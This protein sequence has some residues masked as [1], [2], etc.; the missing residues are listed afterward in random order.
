[1]CGYRPRHRF[2][3]PEPIYR[4]AGAGVWLKIGLIW[5]FWICLFISSSAGATPLIVG[6]DFSRVEFNPYVECIENAPAGLT[7]KDVSSESYSAEFKKLTVGVFHKARPTSV[8]WCRFKLDPKGLRPTS[9]R[10]EL[11]L[12]ISHA[13]VINAILYIPQPGHDG[14]LFL[15]LDSG[16]IGANRPDDLGYLT[17]VFRIPQDFA[18]DRFFYLRMQTPLVHDIKINVYSQDAFNNYAWTELA[19]RWLTIGILVAMILYNLALYLILKERAY[20]FY[21]YF[22]GLIMIHLMVSYGLMKMISYPL[23][24]ALAPRTITIGHLGWLGGLWFTRSFLGTKDH[25]PAVDRVLYFFGLAALVVCILDSAGWSFGVPMAALI[26]LVAIPSVIIL[27]GYVRLRQGFQPAILFLTAGGV[28]ILGIVA[29]ILWLRGFLPETTV[30][31]YAL[32]ACAVGEAVLLSFA[33]AARIRVLQE[34]RH[35]LQERESRLMRL[36]ITDELTGLYNK[37]HFQRVLAEELEHTRRIRSCLSL[38]ML[39]VDHFKK[40]NDT[41]GHPQGDAVLARLGAVLRHNIRGHDQACR[42]GGEEFAV[43]LPGVDI[44]QAVTVAERIR[45]HFAAE[46]FQLHFD[47]TVCATVSLGVASLTH[48]DDPSSFLNRA[49][50]ALYQAKAQGRNRTVRE[51]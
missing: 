42:Y 11:L 39:D 6:P 28:L 32:G 12:E 16:L 4:P 49:D 45:L 21:V 2:I 24:V 50:C 36:S 31:R 33:L 8:T 1:M 38:I 29:H 40:F 20:L 25:A 15:E 18:P 26:L 47:R 44:F 13:L 5:P 3:S 35:R 43:I 22:V 7:I 19:V 9:S 37:R 27:A 17:T 34:E 14:G 23:M 10:P 46:K 41:F 48:D 51:G 30:A